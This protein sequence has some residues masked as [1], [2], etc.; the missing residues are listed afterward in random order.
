MLADAAKRHP[1]PR[2]PVGAKERAGGARVTAWP[3]LCEGR[4]LAASE[5]DEACLAAA[6][7]GV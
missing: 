3:A 4:V 1:K 2:Q 7:G 5:I 6:S